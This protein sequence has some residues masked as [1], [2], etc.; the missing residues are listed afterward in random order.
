[1]VAAYPVS[2]EINSKVD[3]ADQA[4]AR[5]REHY[6]SGETDF[7]DG[8]S[9]AFSDYRFNIRKSNTEPLLRS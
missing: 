9:V 2:G 1:M 7:T 4:I 3:D 6:G 8:L 5:V